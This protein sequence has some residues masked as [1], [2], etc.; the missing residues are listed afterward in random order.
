MI[1][2]KQQRQSGARRVIESPQLSMHVG[3]STLVDSDDDPLI[4]PSI[5]ATIPVSGMLPTWV[6][7]RESSEEVGR[8]GGGHV[9][10]ERKSGEGFGEPPRRRLRLALTQRERTHFQATD[11]PFCMKPRLKPLLHKCQTRRPNLTQ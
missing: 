4:A 11:S 8:L 7:E 1:S 9:P 2:L 10:M 3:G 5:P 6:D